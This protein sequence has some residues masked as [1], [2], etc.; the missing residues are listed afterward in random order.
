MRKGTALFLKKKRREGIFF[1]PKGGEK[2][3]ILYPLPLS[4]PI[5]IPLKSHF[6][7]YPFIYKL[8][9]RGNKK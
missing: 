2:K 6:E 1:S 3:D 4:S 5:H 9:L 7:K 8:S